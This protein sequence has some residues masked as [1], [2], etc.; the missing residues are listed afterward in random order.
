[1]KQ[2]LS[3]R[4]RKR[5]VEHGLPNRVNL[6]PRFKLHTPVGTKVQVMV[7][8]CGSDSSASLVTPAFLPLI[9][10]LS[11]LARMDKTRAHVHH[12]IPPRLRSGF[13]PN[14]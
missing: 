6:S 12:R 5:A 14:R 1:M 3:R 9:V 7:D 11:W 10:L 4:I 2:L 8:E 13:S